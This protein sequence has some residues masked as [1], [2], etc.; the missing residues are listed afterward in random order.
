MASNHKPDEYK[1]G[2]I[3]LHAATV[4]VPTAL[5]FWHPLAGAVSIACWSIVILVIGGHG[6]R[7]LGGN[8][9]AFGISIGFGLLVALF[10]SPWGVLAASAAISAALSWLTEYH[11][12]G[13]EWAGQDVPGFH[14]RL[15]GAGVGII[16]ALVLLGVIA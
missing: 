2:H 1:F 9:G 10:P 6:E 14:N 4:F 11:Q 13:G 16:P 7:A 15:T 8:L 5:A 12:N 3:L